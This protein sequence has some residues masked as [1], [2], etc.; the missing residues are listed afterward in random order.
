LVTDGKL[1]GEMLCIASLTV[2]LRVAEGPRA[3]CNGF[4]F[5]LHGFRVVCR[6]AVCG[7]FARVARP[8]PVVVVRFCVSLKYIFTGVMCVVRFHS[9]CFTSEAAVLDRAVDSPAVLRW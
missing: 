5:G 8:G 4:R 7:L 2:S 6:W 3:R 1:T 9:L